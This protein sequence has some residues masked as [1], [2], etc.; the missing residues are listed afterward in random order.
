MSG[1]SELLKDP[2]WQEK[3]REI[4]QRDYGFCT[5]CHGQGGELHVHHLYYKSGLAP[6]EYPNSAYITLCKFCHKVEHDRFLSYVGPDRDFS[7]KK[8]GFRAKDFEDMCYSAIL[9]AASINPESS[10]LRI[11]REGVARRKKNFEDY[12][13]RMA[14]YPDV[15]LPSRW[16]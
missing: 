8:E 16:V 15:E 3:R 10:I 1:Y 13:S 14:A 12:V 2:R 9:V 7:L 5:D 4:I 6:W 11:A